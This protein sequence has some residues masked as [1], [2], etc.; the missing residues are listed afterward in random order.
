MLAPKDASHEFIKEL[1]KELEA[2]FN[3]RI[4]RV[5]IYEPQK[6]TSEDTEDRLIY[7]NYVDGQGGYFTLD[8]IW[9]NLPEYAGEIIKESESEASLEFER[10]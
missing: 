7:W 2:W 4:Y 10:C 8:E 6:F 3:G 1:V 9:N 5:N